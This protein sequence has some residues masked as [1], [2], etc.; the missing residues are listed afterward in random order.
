MM[1]DFPRRLANEVVDAVLRSSEG[2]RSALS[3]RFGRSNEAIK[4]FRVF[5]F[6]LRANVR[7]RFEVGRRGDGHARHA[8]EAIRELAERAIV[9]PEIVAPLA[10]AVRFVDGNQRDRALF[11][12]IEEAL[13]EQSFGRDVE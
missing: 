4:L 8:G 11:E 6:Q 12:E 2:L 5:E 3:T 13:R 10:D 9:R 1:P 7:L